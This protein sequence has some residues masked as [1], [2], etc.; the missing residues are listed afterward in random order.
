MFH[1]MLGILVVYTVGYIGDWQVLAFV[2][3]TL[4][5][6]YFVLLLLIPETPRWLI[7]K[8]KHVSDLLITLSLHYDCVRYLKHTVKLVFITTKL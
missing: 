1:V 4:P 5:M 7:S 6:V 3:A 2:G 8:C